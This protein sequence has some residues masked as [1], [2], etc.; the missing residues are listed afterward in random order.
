MINIFLTGRTFYWFEYNK[1][2]R[3]I[4]TILLKEYKYDDIIVNFI[5]NHTIALAGNLISKDDLIT[6]APNMF[7]MTCLDDDK[8][9]MDSFSKSLI[10]FLEMMDPQ[11]RG[12]IVII[13]P[14]GIK[15]SIRLE[16]IILTSISLSSYTRRIIVRTLTDLEDDFTSLI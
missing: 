1:T 4:H 8:I 14:D 9:I 3:R 7:F 6:L 16:S 15:N 2:Y 5:K 12:D 11:Y 13:I 10:L